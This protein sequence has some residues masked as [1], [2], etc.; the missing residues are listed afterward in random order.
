MAQATANATSTHVGG[1]VDIGRGAAV[2]T[3][4]GNAT[5]DN[6]DHSVSHSY[7]QSYD[8]SSHGSFNDSSDHSVT[9]SHNT[10][11]DHATTDS[12]N[13]HDELAVHDSY[14]SSTTQNADFHTH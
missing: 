8:Y 5:V 13:T 12:N 7:D 14:N 4:S 2:S 1:N 3:G 6:S 9:D 10:H 11:D